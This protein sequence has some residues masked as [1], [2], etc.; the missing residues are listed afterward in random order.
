M[1][2]ENDKSFSATY[3]TV[4]FHTYM[5]SIYACFRC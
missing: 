3:R 2:D 1:T 5:A 4:C